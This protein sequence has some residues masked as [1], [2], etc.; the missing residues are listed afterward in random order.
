[1]GRVYRM[2]IPFGAYLWS[3]WRT[4]EGKTNLERNIENNLG[5]ENKE[6]EGEPIDSKSRQSFAQPAGVGENV[7]TLM[8]IERDG[9]GG[10]I[11]GAGAR[12]VLIQ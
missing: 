11:E 5:E 1:M 8:S 3:A 2:V 9:N 7:F 4:R 10:H 12:R 6:E